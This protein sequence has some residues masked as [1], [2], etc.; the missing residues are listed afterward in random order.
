MIVRSKA[1]QLKEHQVSQETVQDFGLSSKQCQLLLVFEQSETLASLA[2][3]FERDI[4]VICRQMKKIA[5]MAPVLEKKR[6]IWKLT[7]TGRDL[8]QWTREA[9]ASQNR[10]LMKS[11]NEY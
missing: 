10:I 8:N 4:S 7:Q 2:E 1:I 5:E 3:R 9:I 11:Q 6:G